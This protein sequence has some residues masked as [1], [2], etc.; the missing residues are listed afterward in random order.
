MERE[1]YINGAYLPESR[2]QV[3]VMDRGFLFGDAIYEVTAVVD[4][5]LIDNDLHLARLSRSL[6][7]IGIAMPATLAEICTIQRE[8]VRRNAM[9]DGTI[10]L[11]V[12]RGTQ[13]RNFLPDPD[14]RPTFIALTQPKQLAD[15]RAQTNGIAV[16]LVE[17]P[18][19]L[20]CDIKT[21]QLLGQVLAK[22]AARQGGFDDVWLHRDGKITEGASSSA[23]IVTH[24]GRIVTRPNSP[25]ILPGCTRRAIVELVAQDGLHLDE[26]GFSP[27]EA[28]A[29]AEAFLTSASSLVTP[30]VRIGAHVL[31]DGRPG[32]VTRRLQMLYMQA[33]RR[34]PRIL[35]QSEPHEAV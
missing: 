5:H 24:D 14:I 25:A 31:G 35:P 32:P 7:E 16:D 22:Q 2:A 28:G 18:R 17:D 13:E 9:T 19:W 27:Q 11:Q 34:S 15:T 8:L 4:G 23:F 26:R 3:P 6:G 21:T 33:V 29:A 12:S 1:I 20:R 10:Y 30:V